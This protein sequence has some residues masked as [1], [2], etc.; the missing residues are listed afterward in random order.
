MYWEY[1]GKRGTICRRGWDDNEAAVTCKMFG[2]NYGQALGT[3]EF[4]ERYMPVWIT[5]VSCHGNETDLR[6]CDFLLVSGTDSDC[7]QDL[8]AA[9]VLCSNNQPPGKISKFKK[10][11]QNFEYGRKR[12]NVIV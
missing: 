8:V 11:I 6:Q 5:D 3:S 9:G 1:F 2:F 12:A 4:V 7:A 10:N